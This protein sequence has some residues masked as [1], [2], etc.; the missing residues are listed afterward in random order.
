VKEYEPEEAVAA[1]GEAPADEELLGVHVRP[2]GHDAA[3]EADTAV[4]GP[5]EELPSHR[6]AWPV[7]PDELAKDMAT[8]IG[9]DSDPVTVYELV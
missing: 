8:G 3:V 6:Y 7:Y 2:D 1:C 9:I 5:A 4:E